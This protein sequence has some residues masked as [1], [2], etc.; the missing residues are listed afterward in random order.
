[1]APGALLALWAMER[2]GLRVSL[3]CGYASQLACALLAY[4]ACRVAWPPRAAFSLLYLS[5]VLGALGQPLV[6]NNVTRISG[7]WFPAAERDTAVACALLCVAFGSVFISLYAPVAVTQPAQVGRL[8][9]WQ[10][11]V[12]ALIL[13]VGAAVTA[14]EPDAPPSAGAAVQRAA[15]RSAARRGSSSGEAAPSA[16]AVVAQHAATLCRHKNFT[17]LNVSSGLLTGLVYALATCI[18][19]LMRPCGDSNDAA[20]AALAALSALSAV[21]V[22]VYLYMLR[23]LPGSQADYELR[24]AQGESAK[25]ADAVS[26]ARHPYVAHQIGWSVSTVFGTGLVL[27]AT[28]PGVPQAAV[29][30]AWGTL[31]LLSGTLL[32]AA[33]TMEHAAEMTFPLPANVSVALLGV[34]SSVISFLQVLASTAL[35]QSPRSAGCTSAATPFAAFSAATAAL[36]L[37]CVAAMRP[38]YRRADVEEQA[39]ATLARPRA[40]QRGRG[41]EEAEE[42]PAAGVVTYGATA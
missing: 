40:R 42:L 25:P 5:Q 1:M 39:P 23:A 15:R 9:A 16:L 17:L 37:A 21:G 20:G 11:P 13:A 36:G 26:S 18:G 32:N 34:T 4:A 33:L 22:L 27:A 2:S 12:W 35:L 28:R 10:V 19:Q 38:E 29:V 6:L 41:G 30:A 7:D 24:N 8:F 14:D 3:L 31:G